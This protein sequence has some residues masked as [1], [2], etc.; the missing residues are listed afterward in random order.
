MSERINK[1]LYLA[2]SLLLA[3]VLWLYVDDEL[4]NTTQRFFASVP[5]EFIGA[6]DTLP[7]RN[8]MVT[9][10]ADTRVDLRLSGPRTDIFGMSRE[11]IRI[12]VDLSSISAAGTYTRGLNIYY[13]DDVDSSKISVDSQSRSAVT[14]Q[15]STMYSKTVDVKVDVVN[16]EVAEDRSFMSDLLSWEPST[17]TLSGREED[18]S[19]V[20]SARIEV[21]LAGASSTLRKEFSYEL[22]DS[23]GNVVPSGDIRVSD[24]Q[25]MVT[26][27][28]YAIK[29][30]PLTVKF[31]SSP[32][33]REEDIRWELTETTI[34]VAGEPASLENITEI[35]LGEIDLSMI[36]SNS[37]QR[38]LEIPIPA[39]CENVSGYATT[40][41]DIQFKNMETRTFSVSNISAIGL[42]DVQHFSKVTNSVDVTLR[43][44]AG[45]LD[46]VTEDDI[47]IVVDLTEF[48]AGTVS[49]PAIVLVDGHDNLVGAIGP[50]AV[51]GKITS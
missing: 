5:I 14:V 34:S 16:N 24:K 25:I 23:E 48:G 49:V 29:E 37:E 32:G 8:L 38:T 33:S 45:E 41:I 10:G 7:N 31:K 17:L 46:E 43:G 51:T 19:K 3:I 20:A 42:S 50:Y 11:D 27:P 4:G 21:D 15:V 26:A 35:S 36:L 6:E 18:V 44:P 40:T 1:I 2:L 22:L 28:I 12:Q 39:G 30:L 9:D 47:R 13:A